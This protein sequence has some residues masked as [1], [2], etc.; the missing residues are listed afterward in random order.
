MKKE[1]NNQNL[2]VKDNAKSSMTARPSKETRLSSIS[3]KH[4]TR[5][6]YCTIKKHKQKKAGGRIESYQFRC[7]CDKPEGATKKGNCDGDESRRKKK[8]TT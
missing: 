1:K 4:N 3:C 5:D 6:C 8:L 7:K 2:L